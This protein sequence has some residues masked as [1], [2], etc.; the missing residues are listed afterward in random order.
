MNA[1]RY[2]DCGRMRWLAAASLSGLIYAVFLSLPVDVSMPG[3]KHV[4]APAF[5]YMPTRPESGQDA[6]VSVW[7]PVLFSLPS[8]FGFSG[9]LWEDSRLIQPPAHIQ[10][11]FSVQADRFLSAPGVSA[12]QGIDLQSEVREWLRN[13]E[14]APSGSVHDFPEKDR[15]DIS[16][17]FSSATGSAPEWELHLPESLKSRSERWIA[18]VLFHLDQNGL[19]SSAWIEHAEGLSPAERVDMVRAVRS[20]RVQ[21]SREI[22]GEYRVT[23]KQEGVW[24]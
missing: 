9:P 7:S 8:A 23:V 20:M 6:L 24:R 2:L 12:L 11:G 1:G 22:A 21:P 19:I 17:R 16:V 10:S 4:S 5:R 18:N 13:Y 15:M 14:T 3:K